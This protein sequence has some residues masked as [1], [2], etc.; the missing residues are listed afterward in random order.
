MSNRKA[1]PDILGE[2]LGSPPAEAPLAEIE[3]A[4]PAPDP[5]A[6]S[7][8]QPASGG[9]RKPR[10]RRRAATPKPAL[11]AT[12]EYMTVILA[13]HNGW[14]PH[15][16]NETALENWKFQPRLHE[17]LNVVGGYGW[18]LTAIIDTGRNRKEAYFKRVKS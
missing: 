17:F 10:Q 13:D 9:R 8:P 3:P 12:W 2:I 18:E 14:R 6:E 1:T 7:A 11:R 15:T 16:V 4:D 5:K